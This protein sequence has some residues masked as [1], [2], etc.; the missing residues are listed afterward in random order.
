MLGY[1]CWYSCHDIAS[2]T[3]CSFACANFLA[4]KLHGALLALSWVKHSWKRWPILVRWGA[5]LAR[6]TPNSG[7]GPAEKRR[8]TGGGDFRLQRAML[9]PCFFCKKVPMLR[10][11]DLF[12]SYVGSMLAHLGSMLGAC[13]P[14]LGL[15]WFILAPCW[16]MLWAMLERRVPPEVIL[17]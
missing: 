14:I 3:A 8:R 11:N 9:Q 2:Q 17:G 12:W 16:A 6:F 10:C 4:G 13:S 7:P 1:V 5:D 15:C